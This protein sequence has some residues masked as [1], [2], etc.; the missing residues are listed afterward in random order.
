MQLLS[1]DN[2]RMID[3]NKAAGAAQ[4]QAGDK[5]AEVELIF[6]LQ[7]N[8]CVSIRVGRHDNSFSQEELAQY[9]HRNRVELK[10]MVLPMI[11][12]ARE[13]A[14]KEWDERYQGNE[15]A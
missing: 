1:L 12:P 8:Y 3:R 5:N 9:V 10:Q 11:P 7:S 14:R 13:V 15:Y 6:Y 2:F 4:L